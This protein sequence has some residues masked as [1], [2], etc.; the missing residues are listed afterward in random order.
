MWESRTR[1][2]GGGRIRRVDL[3]RSD[4]PLSFGEVAGLWRDDAKFREFF[5]SELRD[6]PFQAYF[7]ETPPVT[8]DSLAEAFEFVLVDSAELRTVSPDEW[9]FRDQLEGDP[10]G[11]GVAAFWNIGRD[12]LLVAPR[13]RAPAV[14]YTHLAVFAREA[15]LAQQHGFWAAVGAALQALVGPRPVWLSTSGLGVHW[16]HVRLDSY[17]KYYTYAPYRDECFRHSRGK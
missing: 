13:L 3:L 10:D 14:A 7:W 4:V 16:L 5:I 15:P 11:S 9:S 6:A 17:P 1:E 8:E 2:L 12:A